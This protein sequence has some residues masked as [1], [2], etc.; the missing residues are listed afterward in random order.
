MFNICADILRGQGSNKGENE[1]NNEVWCDTEKSFTGSGIIIFLF[2][3]N[4]PS[5]ILKQEANWV[6]QEAERRSEDNCSI[7]KRNYEESPGNF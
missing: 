5:S 1:R 4:H 3:K 6:V 2:H 7:Q